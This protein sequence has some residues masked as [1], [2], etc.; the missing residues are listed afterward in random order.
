M[1]VTNAA[2]VL[3]ELQARGWYLAIAESLTGGALASEFVSVPGASNVLLGSITA[4]QNSIKQ[5]L[6]DVPANVLESRGAVSAETA[7]AMAAGV[8]E[9]FAQAARVPLERV[10]GIATTGVAGPDTDGDKPVGLVYLGFSVP[11][12]GKSALELH[13]SGDRAQIRA[14]AVASAVSELREQ[15]SK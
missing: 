12:L 14:T 4:Y 13:L 9:H 15:I 2:G 10:V 1:S 3:A 5:N 11:G 6:L 8:R 7:E